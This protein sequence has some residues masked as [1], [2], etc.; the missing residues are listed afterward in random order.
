MVHM[1]MEMVVIAASLLLPD[2]ANGAANN[3]PHGYVLALLLFNISDLS[4]IVSRKYAYTYDLAIMYADGD[5]QAV[6]GVLSKYIA[7]VGEY[8]QTWK[9]K[10]STTKTVGSLFHLNY[11]EAK[12]ELKGNFN[13]EILSF[14]SVPSP[15]GG[16]CGLS[17]RKPSSKPP[18]IEIFIINRS[19]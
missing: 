2:T 19:L 9:L 4:Y 13:N 10:L 18:Q 17:P 1:T 8:L 16:F 14:C 11:K 12:R 5:W 3:I 15:R 7:T 6:E